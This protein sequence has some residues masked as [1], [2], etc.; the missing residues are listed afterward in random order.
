MK[1]YRNYTM[2]YVDK[3]LVNK[4]LEE[5]ATT[6]KIDCELTQKTEVYIT[7]FY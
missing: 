1:I 4:Y 2:K 5:I 7:I 6:Y 3:N